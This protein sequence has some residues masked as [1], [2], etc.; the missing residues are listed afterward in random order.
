MT[1]YELY[2]VSNIRRLCLFNSLFK[3]TT[4]KTAKFRIFGCLWWECTGGFTEQMSMLW[5]HQV[6]HMGRRGDRG[7]LIFWF[8]LR[9]SLIMVPT[10]SFQHTSGYICMIHYFIILPLCCLAWCISSALRYVF[11]WI[12][13]ILVCF[14][15]VEAWTKVWPTVSGQ[16]FSNVFSRM[17]IVILWHRFIWRLFLRVQLTISQHSFT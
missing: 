5:H 4:K 17:N 6:L 1:S 10:T 3:L 13:P 15:G 11:K 12:L 14:I 2:G 8:A 7:D 9:I 16:N